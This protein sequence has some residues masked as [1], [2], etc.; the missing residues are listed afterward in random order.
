MGVTEWL[1]LSSSIK[2]ADIFRFSMLG[3]RSAF[4]TSCTVQFVVLIDV[5]LCVCM[6]VCVCVCVCVCFCVCVCVC[7]TQRQIELY[8][9]GQCGLLL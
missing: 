4:S 2:M 3:G 1:S 9:A 7:V 6:C 8:H 5:A